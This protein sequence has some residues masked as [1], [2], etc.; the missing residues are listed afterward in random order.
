MNEYDYNSSFDL[1]YLFYFCL[2]FMASIAIYCFSLKRRKFF[3]IP[4]ILTVAAVETFGYFFPYVFVVGLPLGTAIATVIMFVGAIFVFEE[5]IET[6][7]TVFL[8]GLVTNHACFSVWSMILINT[9]L[10][11]GD[12]DTIQLI[13]GIA[14]FIA[15]LGLIYLIFARRITKSGNLA[16][17]KPRQ[18]I[19]LVVFSILIVVL[20]SIA[21]YFRLE[22]FITRIY[23]CVACVAYLFLELYINEQLEGEL[24][25]AKIESLLQ[26][27]EKQRAISEKSA[28][29]L[30]IKAH[31]LKHQLG[32]LR[33]NSEASDAE[34]KE[35]EKAIAQYDMLTQT[36]NKA[37]DAVVAEYAP[38]MYQENV[39]FTAIAD[40]EALSIFSQSDVYSFFGN[41]IS[42]AFEAVKKEDVDN[43][44]ISIV[45]RKNQNFASFHIEN[46]SS[47]KPKSNGKALK[48]TKMDLSQHGYGTKSMLYIAQKY[49]GHL[50]YN[51]DN[52]IF[53]VDAILPLP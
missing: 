16:I 2:S 34:I 17:K 4:V 7:I 18:K 26:A 42:N 50:T 53:S 37:F 51:Y 3:Y 43:R 5:K 11:V 49:N 12:N 21:R 25:K 48:S 9:P 52:G 13:S 47:R 1:N 32:L 38:S 35:M 27:E 46:Y 15:M 39:R 6:L 10:F 31:D 33:Q 8:L 40:P 30:N 36:G 28:E 44:F 19:Y 22:N 29:M 14:Y 20:P 23:E 24:E 45:I 41:V